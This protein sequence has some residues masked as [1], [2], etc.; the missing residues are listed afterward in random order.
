[1]ANILIPEKDTPKFLIAL[2]LLAGSLCLG[3]LSSL[4]L[5]FNNRTLAKM[6]RTYVQMSDGSA[7]D[8]VQVDP[9]HREAE[10]LKST[11]D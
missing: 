2:L 7:T 1:M 11:N 10:V 3:T 4:I 6:D 9:L 8:I 5:I